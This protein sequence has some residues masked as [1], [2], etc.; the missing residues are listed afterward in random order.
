[1]MCNFQLD[2]DIVRDD[3]I[4]A[5]V[6]VNQKSNLANIRT[7]IATAMSEVETQILTLGHNFTFQRRPGQ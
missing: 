2:F 6:A 4:L 5:E 3:D 1:M 7:S